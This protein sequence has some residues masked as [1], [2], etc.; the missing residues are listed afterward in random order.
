MPL[1]EFYGKECPHCVAMEPIIEKLI[2]EG[3]KIER[4]ETWH[5]KKN[6]A[7]RKKMDKGFCGGVPFFINTETGKWI[8]GGSDEKTLRA[9]AKGECTD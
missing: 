4:H 8:C 6:E 3:V 1:I 5:D 2:E 9:L 7:L